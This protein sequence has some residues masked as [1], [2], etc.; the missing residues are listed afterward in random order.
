MIGK[1]RPLRVLCG[2]E[3]LNQTSRLSSKEM[4]PDDAFEALSR[5]PAIEVICDRATA[6]IGVTLFTGGTI[7]TGGTTATGVP[8]VGTVAGDED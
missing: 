5:A 7:G 2:S 6:I 3:N 8:L 1:R 4:P